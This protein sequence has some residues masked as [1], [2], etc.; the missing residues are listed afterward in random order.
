MYLGAT[1]KAPG[2][3]VA[4]PIE[5][6]CH[7]SILPI[8]N[9]KKKIQVLNMFIVMIRLQTLLYNWLISMLTCI[10]HFC[11]NQKIINQLFRIIVKKI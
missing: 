8:L 2:G 7:E 5:K 11:F 3:V 1:T 6:S 10:I 9:V 4:G